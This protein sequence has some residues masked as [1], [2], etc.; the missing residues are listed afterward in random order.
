MGPWT[1]TEAAYIAGIVDGEGSIYSATT[2]ETAYPAIVVAMTDRAVIDWLATR[3]GGTVQLH[4]QTNLRREVGLRRQYRIGATGARAVEI[5]RRLLP[6]LRVKDGQ[7]TLIIECWRDGRHRDEAGVPLD[8]SRM[9]LS[10]QLAYL[11][12]GIE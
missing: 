1:E 11:N 3:W 9:L 6:Y 12:R 7:A 5:C 8:V 4:N 2:R 10:E